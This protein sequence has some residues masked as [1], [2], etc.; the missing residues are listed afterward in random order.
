[1]NI[2]QMIGNLFTTNESSWILKLDDK[3]INSVVIQKFLSLYPKSKKVARVLAKYV[4]N[5]EPKMY[6]SCAWSMLFFNGKKL[7]KAPF[8]QFPKKIEKNDK[9]GVIYNKL[10]KQFKLS[11][12][13]FL[14]VKEFI[15]KDIEKNK[16]SWFCYYNVPKIEWGKHNLNYD[17]MKEYGGRDV[18]KVEK[19]L[20]DF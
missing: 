4:Y 6:L 18:K 16:S 11:D 3:D 1:M 15:D 8:I 17:L 5:I 12:N 13:D 7:T 20:F 14:N 9:Y 19:T 10:K 2:F